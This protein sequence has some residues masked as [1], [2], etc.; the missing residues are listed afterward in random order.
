M[1]PLLAYLFLAI[2]VFFSCGREDEE[3]KKRFVDC[4]DGCTQEE[5]DSARAEGK[6]VYVPVAGP[7][8]PAGNRGVMGPTGQNGTNGV[9]GQDGS[10]GETGLPG[11]DGHSVVFM[12][13]TATTCTNGGQTI[14]L[15][16]D[17]NDNGTLDLATDGNLSSA[18]ICN[19]GDGEDGEDGDD[20]PPSPFT[21]VGLIDPCG[22]KPSVWDEVL[23]KLYDGSLLAS[24][25]D[26][27][28]GA[29]TRLSVLPAGTYMTTDGDACVFTVNASLEV[30]GESHQN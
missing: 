11:Q 30:V 1:K 23:L 4:Y 24:F 15:A 5:I 28:N 13:T 14:L 29:N 2:S 20:A 17:A 22:D 21:P 19:G 16:T 3:W 12:I 9:D 18:T 26:N 6:V 8:G 27:A 25:S 10:T 7:Q